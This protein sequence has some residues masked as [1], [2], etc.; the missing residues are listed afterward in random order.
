VKVP[1]WMY[2]KVQMW[3]GDR[4]VLLGV[5][6][7]ELQSVADRHIVND[8]E[9]TGNVWL[10]VDQLGRTVKCLTEDNT[11]LL[12]EKNILIKVWNPVQTGQEQS[13]Y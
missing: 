5:W 8:P 6:Q 1:A 4:D 12:D 3:C 11:K 10:R 9:N 2:G 7:G 13:H